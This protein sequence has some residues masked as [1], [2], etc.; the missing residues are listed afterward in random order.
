MLKQL[1]TIL[2]ISFV[3]GTKRKQ[4]KER[5]GLDELSNRERILGVAYGRSM[6]EVEEMFDYIQQSIEASNFDEK[7]ANR[8]QRILEETTWKRF[9]ISHGVHR[10]NL[11]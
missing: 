6:E 11:N 5:K 8:L 4:L 1:V 10:W 3:G 2:F 9:D 7:A